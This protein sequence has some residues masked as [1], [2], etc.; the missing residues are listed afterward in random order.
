MIYRITAILF[1]VANYIVCSAQEFGGPDSKWVY[2]ITGFQGVN[3]VEFEKDTTINGLSFNKFIMASQHYPDQDLSMRPLFLRNADGLV[4]WSV[5]G[6]DTDTLFNFNAT[7]GDR[8]EMPHFKSWRDD[9]YVF[10]VVDTFTTSFMNR[11]LKA[12]SYKMHLKGDFEPMFV[13]TIMEHIGFRH[14]FILPFDGFDANLDFNIGGSLMCFQNDLLGTIALEN[15]WWF[16]FW[17]PYDCSQLTSTVHI[18][19]GY[20][21]FSLYPNPTIGQVHISD[22]DNHYYSYEIYD[23]TGLGVGS[24]EGYGNTRIDVSALGSG[25]YFLRVGDRVRRFVKL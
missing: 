11:D 14:S 17:F 18:E 3:T 5:D 16:D 15:N 21:E 24:G 1:V 6:L 13:D 10:D 22:L 20:S 25:I 7:P 4:R 8:W 23:L 12:L 2:N 9:I 19:K